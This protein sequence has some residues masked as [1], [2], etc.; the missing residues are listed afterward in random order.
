MS[1]NLFFS[2]LHNEHEAHRSRLAQLFHRFIKSERNDIPADIA[3]NLLATIRDLLSIR[4]ALP[5]EPDETEADPLTDAVNNPALIPQHYLFETAGILTS[6]LFRDPQQQTTILLGLVKPLLNDLAVTLPQAKK[7]GED[8]L[9]TIRVCHI[10]MALGSIAKGF[11]DFPS[12]PPEGYIFPPLDIFTQMTQ[13]ITVC[14]EE[15]KELRV[16][17]DAVSSFIQRFDTY[18]IVLNRPGA[19]FQKSWA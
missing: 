19:P 12:T 4:V 7:G 13:A 10:V 1:I 3:A 9:P 15:M 14:L 18:L 6:L 5:T 11:P 8:I 17:R 2:G 16:V